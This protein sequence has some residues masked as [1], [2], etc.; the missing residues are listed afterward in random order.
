MMLKGSVTVGFLALLVGC[1]RAPAPEET[2]PAAQRSEL[3]AAFDA[4]AREYQVPVQILESIAYVE[5]RV[6]PTAG[7]RSMAG[8]HGIMA[9]VDRE[10]WNMLS[11]AT[12][13]TG[14]KA[15]QLDVDARAN[16]RGAA[17]VLRELADKSFRDFPEL[18]AADPG[19]WYHAVSLYPGY[20][21]ASD[22]HDYAAQ[23]FVRME[24]GFTV[25]E[26][27]LEPIATTWRD[28]APATAAKRDALNGSDYPAAVRF[29][30]SPHYS[31]GRSTYE[32]VVIH[33]MQGSYSGCIS[34]FQ[35][36]SSNVSS[37]YV[38]RSSDGEITQMVRDSNTAW[39]AQCYNGRSIGIEHEGFV[40]DPARWY[41]PAMY[42]ESAK[43][44]RWLTDR[45][46]IPRTRTRIIGHREVAPNCNT[47]GH[48]D[49]GAGW[50]W[51]HYMNL[52]NGTTP[53]PTS[54]V[55]TG[56]IY[57]GGDPN[58]RLAGA[59]VTVN[60]Q[61][62]TTGA[63]GIYQFTLPP[64]S[65]NATVTKA[66]F[67]TNTVTRAVTAGAT[68]WGSMEIN[69]VTAATGTLRG[70]VY[71]YNAANPADLSASVSGAVVTVSPGG[72]TATT[73]ADGN[74]VFNLAP[75]TYTVTATKA[76]FANN[77]Q[78]RTVVS[79][80]TVWGS[81]GLTTTTMA[82]A[83]PPVVSIAFPMN[84]AQLDLAVLD[85]RGTASD[86]RGAVANVK[87]SLNGGA[88][89]DVAV[90]GG[91]F[92]VQV[93]LKPGTNTLKVTAT[94]AAGNS[95]SAEST[96][97]FNAGVAGFVYA[98]D[99]E[100]ARVAGAELELFEPA[101]GVSVS[102]ATAD[103][104]GAFTLGV[105]TVPAD[106]KLVVKAAGFGT[107]VETVTVGDDRRMTLD[108]SLMPGMVGPGERTVSF[109][110]PQDGATVNTETV[111]VYGMVSGFEMLSVKVN[112]VAGELLPG[113]TAFSATVPLTEG[114]NTLKA[115]VTSVDGDVL[116]ATL[117]VTR[118]LT[119]GKPKDDM[120]AKGGCSAAPGLELLALAALGALLR[121]RGLRG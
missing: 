111:T 47:G 43:L 7:L 53:T 23:V 32:F 20:D 78:T 118:K 66:G 59:V 22:A 12:A 86:D 101:S 80:Q 64:G 24:Q 109:T 55:L 115:E 93:K 63:N 48:T 60:G 96:A 42:T 97:T 18:D 69:A 33:T 34:W 65:Y 58:N 37:Q 87:L 85:V 11:R 68:I 1:G 81:V 50:N 98:E 116:S 30:P 45:Y 5:T 44:T 113:G 46:N 40:A 91:T 17:A 92:T 102:K 89:A 103:A 99:N 61:S 57:T 52:V 74:W 75:G 28:N 19:D 10:D 26:L 79:G 38:V 29:T 100:T 54:G 73:A 119:T 6:S 2:A 49:P 36:P 56:A 107:H 82:D 14:A 110:E 62:V 88:P 13:L 51:T 94:D 8:G 106:Y 21:S 9:I 71:Q 41:T 3:Q 35:N 70:K 114:E 117:H 16:I 31:S 104:M 121:R 67:G 15:G 4:A 83:Q 72:A 77:T 105:M 25:P 27:T 95:A 84:A 120:K 108:V 76:G 90:T 112:G 39:H